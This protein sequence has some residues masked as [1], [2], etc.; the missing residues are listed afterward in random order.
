M[1]GIRLVRPHGHSRVGFLSVARDLWGWHAHDYRY[2]CDDGCIYCI[3]KIELQSGFLFKLQRRQS[4]E[5]RR[6]HPQQL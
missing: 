2:C 1:L 4:D 5:Q 3:R 6:G